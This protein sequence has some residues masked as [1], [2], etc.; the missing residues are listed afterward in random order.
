MVRGFLALGLEVLAVVGSKVEL[1][2][3]A[4][5]AVVVSSFVLQVF[6]REMENS[7]PHSGQNFASLGNSVSQFEQCIC[8]SP[9]IQVL[10]EIFYVRVINKWATDHCNNKSSLQTGFI[11]T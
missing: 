1:L 2:Q 5:L 11:H 6:S 8:C 10:I 7:A 9:C 4:G 3:L